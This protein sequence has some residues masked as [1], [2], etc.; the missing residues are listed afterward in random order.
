MVHLA[1]GLCLPEGHFQG[2]WG[3]RGTTY[4]SWA[5]ETNSGISSSVEFVVLVVKEVQSCFDKLT[6]RDNTD[7]RF[8]T[9]KKCVTKNRGRALGFKMYAFN[10][11]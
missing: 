2:S 1:T 9:T 3:Y 7:G 11:L 8:S 10:L 5:S 4:L 6:G